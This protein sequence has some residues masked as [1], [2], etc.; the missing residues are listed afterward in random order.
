M[1]YQDYCGIPREYSIIIVTSAVTHTNFTKT[2]DFL[3]VRIYIITLV[4]YEKYKSLKS[5]VQKYIIISYLLK[6][7]VPQVPITLVH[8]LNSEFYLIFL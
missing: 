3:T 4:P 1:L 6:T 8:K 7:L 5:N 2:T